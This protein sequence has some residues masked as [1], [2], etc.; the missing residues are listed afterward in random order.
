MQ[1]FDRSKLRFLPLGRRAGG[2]SIEQVAVT[3]LTPLPRIADEERR[4]I[5]DIAASIAAARA[6][7]SCVILAFGAHLIKNGLAP[8][9]IRMVED[10]WVTHLATNGAGSI[11]DW[12]FAYQG[13][14]SED[15]R[16]NVASGTFGLWEETGATINLAVATGGLDGLGYGWSVGRAVCENGIAIPS[17]EDLL[18]ILREAGNR[19]ED[20]ERAAAAADLL[21][22]VEQLNLSPGFL[23]VTHRHPAYSVQAAAWR[24]KVPFTVHPGI[25]YD[26]TATHPAFSGGAIGRGAYRDFLAYAAAVSR[27]T[28]GVHITVGSAIM[29]PMIFEKSLSMVN[30]IRVRREGCV[31]DFLIVV[32][33]IQDAGWD[34]ENQEPPRD[35]PSYFFRACKT[36]SRMGGRFVYVRMDNRAFLQTLWHA[37]DSPGKDRRR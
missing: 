4:R 6:A 20:T 19:P 28:G 29:A 32:N 35:S 22:L 15:V 16:A 30:N 12:E 13:T 18:G 34:W 8:L 1:R 17:R 9:V 14:T 11:H 37:L 23:S 3:P 24:A 10:G 27:L 5:E 25:G 31:D 7:G 33:D 36:F 26:I 21:S 2:I